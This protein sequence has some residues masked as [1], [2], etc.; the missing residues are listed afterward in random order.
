MSFCSSSWRNRLTFHGPVLALLLAATAV[1]YPTWLS[2]KP[3]ALDDLGQL[4][5]P[6]R[7]LLA[8][9]YHHGHLPLWNPFNFAGQPFLAAGQSGPLYIPNVI[10]L[11]LPIATALK[12]S[13]LLHEWLAAVGMYAVVWHY[14]E[15]R[16]AAFTG[17]ITFVTCGFLLGHEIHTQMFDAFCWLPLCFWLL[18][19][20]LDRP[21]LGRTLLLAGAFA[22]EIYA[23][24]PQMTFYTCLLLGLYTLLRW[25]QERRIRYAVTVLHAVSACLLGLGLSAPQWL[26]TLDLANYSDRAAVTPAFLLNGSL[27][28]S[29]LA[30]FF[31][32]FS[33]GGGYTGVP[34]SADKFLS[35]Y[36]INVYWEFLCYV[37]IVALTLATAVVV[38]EF[39]KVRAILPLSVI[40]LFSLGL[41]LGANSAF[42]YVLVDLPGFDLFRVPARYVGIVDFLIAVLAGIAVAQLCQR[43]NLRLRRTLAAIA[44][45]YA[46]LC[47]VLRWVGPLHQTPTLAFM[48]PMVLLL[49]TAAINLPWRRHTPMWTS[50]VITGLVALDAVSQSAGL[51][52]LVLKSQAPYASTTPA[53]QFLKRALHGSPAL[54]YPFGR[55]A[56]LDQTSISQ[57]RVLSQRI[58]VLNGEDSLEPAWY[59]H[60]IDLTWN[61]ATLLQ[62]PLSLWN[63]LDVKYVVTAPGDTL[64]AAASLGVKSWSGVFPATAKVTGTQTVSAN[65]AASVRVTVSSTWTATDQPIFSVTLQ[66]GNQALQ[67]TMIGPA[68]GTYF[69][70]LPKG[71]PLDV[72][73]RIRIDNENRAQPFLLD[74]VSL[75]TGGHA[76]TLPVDRQLGPQAWKLVGETGDAWIWENP[77]PL[78]AAWVTPDARAPGLV[79]TDR[80]RLLSWSPNRQ[81]WQVTG[82][83]AGWFVLSQM[84]DPNW[85]ATVTT[86]TGSG[87]TTVTH[88][89]AKRI[90]SVLTGVAVSSGAS[91]VVLRYRPLSLEIG[92]AL[93]LLTLLIMG[94][95]PSV[96]RR[97]KRRS[98]T[99]R[100]WR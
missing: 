97:I 36:G 12:V 86:Q 74:A 93:A 68:E 83:R 67:K 79:S 57:D 66:A 73:T 100:D 62:Q 92:A 80:T 4:N 56:S 22:M 94:L 46:V 7:A 77:N 25:L 49:V 59:A 37:G 88:M 8:W 90:G 85:V 16:M 24:H 65:H 30:Q 51:S 82:N 2:A 40:T 81:V 69:I 75:D 50:V 55:A 15:R 3:M 53:A 20:L 41:A 63:R 19:R 11:V 54:P 87:R 78:R 98:E 14:T 29:G 9:F 43:E 27:P 70:A 61:D 13:Y 58:P 52:T 96:S 64:V 23:G 33:A 91:T 45:V 84:Y 21:T 60:N 28:F 44:L 47:V 34:F 89:R 6:Q 95:L 71:W 32:P 5:G 42:Q 17:A 99:M 31:T 39:R 38:S 76:A 1:A 35:L 26:P 18:L 72:P 10:Y 48:A